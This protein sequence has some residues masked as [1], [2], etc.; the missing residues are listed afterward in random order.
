MVCVFLF[1]SLIS[2]AIYFLLNTLDRCVVLWSFVCGCR[3]FL[4]AHPSF[5]TPL[6]YSF[7]WLFV[8][9]MWDAERRFRLCPILRSKGR[10]RNGHWVGWTDISDRNH[11][12]HWTQLCRQSIARSLFVPTHSLSFPLLLTNH[13]CTDTHT[14]PQHLVHGTVCPQLQQKSIELQLYSIR[15]HY[16]LQPK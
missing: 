2:I 11:H 12:I 15:M 5:H 1:L 9:Y 3:L 14:P 10:S 7:L 4:F 8:A 13:A 6:Y 16:C